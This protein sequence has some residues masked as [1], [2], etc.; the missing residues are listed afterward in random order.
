MSDP[1]DE[2]P[3][4]SSV[5]THIERTLLA[6]SH[7][8][9]SALASQESTAADSPS[10]TSQPAAGTSPRKP[11]TAIKRA[12]YIDHVRHIEELSSRIFRSDPMYDKDR[13][14]W[15]SDIIE[16]LMVL[17]GAYDPDTVQEIQVTKIQSIF[18][19]GKAAGA[20]IPPRTEWKLMLASEGILRGSE[21][22]RA[23]MRCVRWTEGDFQEVRPELDPTLNADER[24]R[25]ACRLEKRAEARTAQPIAAIAAGDRPVPSSNATWQHRGR[26]HYI[27]PQDADNAYDV[28]AQLRSWATRGDAPSSEDGGSAGTDSVGVI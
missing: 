22:Y 20:Y 6:A 10:L 15:E 16:P 26:R 17:W 11:I 9:A 23:A 18:T 2:H 14:S 8:T 27:P 1:A 28:A 24:T 7:A 3:Q 25:I 21:A 4:S 5:P 13:N 12:E 19:D